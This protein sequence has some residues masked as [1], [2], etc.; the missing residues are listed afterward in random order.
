ASGRMLDPAKIKSKK[1]S[2]Y[3]SNPFTSYDL[4]IDGVRDFHQQIGSEYPYPAHVHYGADD[5]MLTWANTHWEG[6]EIQS[7]SGYQ[8]DADNFNGKLN[9]EGEGR[10]ITLRFA[11][12]RDSGDGTVPTESGAAPASGTLKTC[13]RQGNEGGGALVKFNGKG[14]DN[15]YDHQNSYNDVRS[16]WATLYGVIMLARMAGRA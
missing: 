10:A 5:R 13:F 14:R 7:P 15:G 6:P 1:S 9:I 11:A 16:Q 4:M 12:A 3:K 2:G 8:A